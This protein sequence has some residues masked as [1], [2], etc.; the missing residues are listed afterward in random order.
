[1]VGTPVGYPDGDT[2]G[3]AEGMA[4]G[5][6]VVGAAV[7][8]RHVGYINGV[9]PLHCGSI[10]IS[11]LTNLHK[12]EGIDPPIEFLNKFRN[13]RDRVKSPKELGIAPVNKF[14]CTLNSL[15]VVSTFRLDGIVPP[16]LFRLRAR[17]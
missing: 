4:V 2:E 17:K 9:S 6:A 13:L 16:R 7:G 11:T 3:T 1:M 14:L 15:K 10:T 12:D 5:F 8:T